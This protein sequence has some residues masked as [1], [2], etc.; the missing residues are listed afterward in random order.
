MKAELVK[1]RFFGGLSLPEAAAA[2]GMPERTARRHWTFARAW[3]RDA[4]EGAE[5]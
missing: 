5:K 1:L 2:L 4:V 3:L